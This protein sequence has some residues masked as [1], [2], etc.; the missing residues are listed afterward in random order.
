MNQY[1]FKPVIGYRHGYNSKIYGIVDNGLQYLGVV[2]ALD[3]DCD[4]RILLFKMREDFGQDVQAGAFVCTHHN[5]TAWHALGFGDRG[6]HGLARVQC[7]FGI[8]KEQ[9]ARSGQRYF[10]A[11]AVE[12]FGPDLFF[13][14]ANLRGDCRLRTE[15]FLRSP[16]ETRQS[17]DLD[18]CFQLVEIHKE[19]RLRALASGLRLYFAFRE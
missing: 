17:R 7:V 2:G 13:Q 14:G 3:I 5:F 18:K 11:R 9:L 1:G 10:A 12:K 15:T 4:I 8:L 16:R 6:S 19:K